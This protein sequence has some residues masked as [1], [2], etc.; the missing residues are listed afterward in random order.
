MG[1]GIYAKMILMVVVLSMQGVIG[2]RFVL[3]KE[4]CVSYNVEYE[5]ETVHI[6][7]VA[8]KADA[9]WHYGEDGIDLMVISFHF[10]PF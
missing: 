3:N 1:S 9:T 4:E 2:I 8:I 10:F 6:S 7:F 5:G